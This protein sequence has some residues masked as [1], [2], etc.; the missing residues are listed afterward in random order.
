MRRWLR[1]VVVVLVLGAAAV[2]LKF[3]VFRPDPVPV[4]VFRVARGRVEETVTNSRAGTVR[5]RLRASLSPALAGRVAEVGVREG[6]RVAAGQL[7]LRL[8]DE[9]HRAQVELQE[10]AVE[11]ARAASREACARAD[12]AA[13]DLDRQRR[14]A[15]D[16]IVSQDALEQAQAAADVA[17]AA[18]EAARAE[19]RRVQAALEVA[20]V[21]LER[22][23]TRA[24][25]DGVVAEVRTEVGEWLTPAPPGVALPPIID[26]FDPSE[27]YVSAPLDEIDVA[28]I[29]V[30]Q[31][32]R[33]T[34]DAYRDEAFAG[35][36]VRV[37]PYVEDMK[38]QSRTFE[39]EVEI[40]D[41]D[42]AR[43][44]RP[45]ITADVEVI[46]RVEEAALRVPSYA[47][48]E[49]RSTLVLRDGVLARLDVETGLSNWQ[50]AEV[51]SGLVDGDLVVVSLDR[52][53]VK[54]G[55]RARVAGETEK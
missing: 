53:E 12:Q 18:C 38:E 55:A 23:V 22:T 32:V 13:R 40:D 42:F 8:D 36:V 20:R 34:L 33:V 43:G 46:L 9:E 27:V 14:L 21:T 16:E 28:R 6:D 7:L 48:I 5:S 45:G 39:I 10:R 54:E 49:G 41:E 11:A 29:A 17:R 47:L 52:A 1:R 3:T 24:P 37:A 51:R 44:L 30:G 50:F 31:A 25:F 35:R 2:A 19:I 26:L 15:R 4:T